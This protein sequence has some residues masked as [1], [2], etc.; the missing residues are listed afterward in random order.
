MIIPY[1]NIKSGKKEQI[2]FMFDKIAG[3]YDF[4]NHFLSLGIDKIW[5]RNAIKIL[6]K[7]K[8]EKIL[9][10]ATGT[11]DFAIEAVKLN[12]QEIIGI[13]I[14]NEMLR[15]GKKKIKKR[16]LENIISFIEGNSE[17]LGFENCSFNAAI[18]AFGVRNFENL[19][20]CLKET[21]RVLKPGG[22]FIVIE[23]SMPKRFPVK[24]LYNFYFFRIL[25]LLGRIFSKDKS[26]YNYLPESVN[27]FPDEN[28]FINVLSKAGFINSKFIS[29]TFGIASIYCGTKP[30]KRL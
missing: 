2:A 6:K 26:A 16:K 9:D 30:E 1:K 13:D 5:R 17:N 28:N 8:P 3:N 15:I 25:P 14:S 24:Q 10:I 20:L 18:V 4:L 12:P 21:Y 22:V 7:Y 23:F 19:S 27:A 29:Q 11:G